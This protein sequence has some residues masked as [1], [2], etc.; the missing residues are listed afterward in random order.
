MTLT[1]STVANAFIKFKRARHDALDF[2]SGIP[3]THPSLCGEERMCNRRVPLE[4]G[5][6]Y[7]CTGAVDVTKLLRGSRASLLDKAVLLGA[8][9]LVEESWVCHIRI[10]K[11]KQDGKFRVQIRYYASASR[12]SLPDPQKPVAL[13]KVTNVPG[14]MTIVGREEIAH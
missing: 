3:I 7:V 8:N 6:R 14:L 2:A 9:V 13:E 5:D 12:S 1:V 10:P 11:N 4:H